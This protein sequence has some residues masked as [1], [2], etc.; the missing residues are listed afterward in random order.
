MNIFGFHFCPHEMVLLINLWILGIMMRPV[1]KF[2]RHRANTGREEKN[3]GDP[4][5]VV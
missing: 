1:L 5:A 2:R 3:S 4:K